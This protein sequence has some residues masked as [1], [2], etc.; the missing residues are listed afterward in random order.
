L[1]FD[2]FI[3][4]VRAAARGLARVRDAAGLALGRKRPVMTR[5]L[6]LG[7][8]LALTAC[9]TDG[10][11]GAGTVDS[12]DPAD[13]PT[14]RQVAT[15]YNANLTRLKRLWAHGVIEMRWTDPDDKRHYEQ[16]EITLVMRMPNE[17]ALPIQKL[18]VDLFWLGSNADRFWY[19]DLRDEKVAYVATHDGPGAR[20]A[21]RSL[22]APVRPHELPHLLGVIPVDLTQRDPAMDEKV[23]RIDG[24]DVFTLPGRPIRLH[25]APKSALPGRIDL[26]DADGAV[27]MTSALSD[28]DMVQMQG[29]PSGE[30]S[31]VA[32]RVRITVPDSDAQVLIQTSD[33]TDDPDKVRDRVFDFDFL[34]RVKKT[35]VV[36]LDAESATE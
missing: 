21:A 1:F 28:F 36:D 14:V 22:P 32:R 5:A 33:M 6:L 11:A 9:Q 18:G 34:A 19:L 35:R 3:A 12:A 23:A 30:R 2:R 7:V 8:T 29:V 4:F 15:R 27:R 13:L 25:V 24:L 20:R 10:G 26:L 16:G 17:L 31:W